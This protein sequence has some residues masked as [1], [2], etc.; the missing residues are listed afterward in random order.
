MDTLNDDIALKS[1]LLGICTWLSRQPEYTDIPVIDP[2]SLF[3][4][5]A[6]V[7]YAR[8]IYRF[9]IEHGGQFLLN[10]GE[11]VAEGDNVASQQT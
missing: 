1:Y 11:S 6:P 9:H 7:Q 5:T 3:Y 8:F 2:H 10:Q 4:H